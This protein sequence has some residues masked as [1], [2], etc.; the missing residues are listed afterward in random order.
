MIGRILVGIVS[1]VTWL[2]FIYILMTYL[3]HP[4]GIWLK[5]PHLSDDIWERL[6]MFIHF[7]GGSIISVVGTFQ[8]TNYFWKT[9]IHPY[10][11]ILYVNGVILASSG[12]LIYILVN[13]TIGGLCMDVAFATNG[14]ILFIYAMITAYFAVKRQTDRHLRWAIRLYVLGTSSAF[15]RVLYYVTCFIMNCRYVNFRGPLDHVY[16]WIYFLIPMAISE[17]YLLIRK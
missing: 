2:F 1:P 14:I 7:I 8:L 16:D 11:G 3:I 17:I 5:L 6:P 4:E 12:G 15:Y 10:T 13:G 9:R